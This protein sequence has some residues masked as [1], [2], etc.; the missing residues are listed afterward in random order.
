MSSYQSVT[1][2]LGWVLC[3]ALLALLPAGLAAQE[4]VTI[5]GKVTGSGGEPLRDV[6][7]TIFDVGVGAWTGADGIYHLNVPGGRAQGQ[8]VKMTARLIGFRAGA[9]TVTLTAGSTLEQNFQ[10]ASDPLRLEEVVVTGAGT[11]TQRERLATA[12][13]KVDSTLFQRSNEQNVVQALAGKVP[14]VLTNQGSG[15]AGASTAIVIRGPKSFGTSQPVILLD[16]V[17]LNNQTRGQ[18]ILSGAPATNRAA[19]ISPDD[20]EGGD[21]LS[22]AASTSIYGASAGSAGAIELRSKHGHAGPTT[23]NL[24]STITF[25]DP[26]RTVPVQTKY[27]VGSLGVS[28]ACATTN[29]FIGSNFFSW[30]PAIPDSVP[31]FNHGAEIFETGHTIDNALSISGGNERTTFYLSMSELNQDGFIVSNQDKYERY[32]ARFAGSH[33]LFENLTVNA[34]VQV[35]QTKNT[36]TDRGNSINGVGISALRQPPDFNATQFLGGPNNLHRSWRFPN[37]GPT[38]FT[39]NRGFDNPFYALYND[40]LQGQTGRYLGN[41]N[42][43]WK[44]LLWLSVNW[45]LGG[46]YNADDRTY[47]YGQASSG[48]SGGSIERWQFYDRLFDHT[49]TA[50]ATHQFS[51]RFNGTFTVGQNLNET[52]FRQIDVFGQTWLAP[53]PYKLSNTTTRTLPNDA[54][55]RRRIEGY[56]AQ[57]NADLYDQLFLQA[58][59]RNDAN[60]AFGLGHQHAWYPGASVAWAFSKAVHLP[61]RYIS[62]GKLRT[63]YGQSGNPPPLYA[64]QSVYTTASFADF[65]P[66]SLQGTTIN[67]VGGLYVSNTVGNPNISPER[68]SELEAGLDLS[69]FQG[70]A[71]LS[72]TRYDSKSKDVIFGVA[73]APSTGSTNINLNAGQISNKGWELT[74]GVRVLQRG[75]LSIELSGNWAENRNVVTS[76][77]ATQ[78]QLDGLVP[79]PTVANCGPE[80]KVARCQIGIGSSF[81]GQTTHAQVGYPIGVWRSTDFARC[82]RGL[83]TVSFAGT[84]YDVGTACAGAPDG[85][86]Y[87]APNGFPITD[88]TVR[89][90]GNPWPDWT[91]GLAATVNYKGFQLTAFLD[92]RQGGDVLNMTRSSMDQYGTHFDTQRRGDSVTFGSDFPCYNQT[93]GVLNGPVVGPGAGTKV[94]LGEGWFSNAALAGSGQGATG[95]PITT[96]LEDGTFTRLREV[97]LSYSF[98]GRW[99]SRMAG[100]RQL[101]VKVS[102][103]N[104]GLWSH[105]SGYDP[106]VNL[107]GAQNANRGIDWFNAPLAHS[108]IMQLTLYH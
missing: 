82:G 62:Y 9:A 71:D 77:G 22:G 75:N 58:R 89:A 78:D 57:A 59:V 4:P 2:P 31:V 83:T 86:L 101:D 91:M 25:D 105:Y 94:V 35:I 48:Q 8:Q 96:R 1:R 13:P 21:I 26:V 17:P 15:D 95:G 5:S 52:Y 97:S 55:Q 19:D 68:V 108:Y 79:M 50:V 11:E 10:L 44:P 14:N 39:N 61:E 76:L 90:I 12:T 33:S 27:G 7:V 45:T 16:G 6:N 46:D 23:Y 98:R 85:A 65:N 32:T 43:N 56:F 18:A 51:P 54:E 37:P 80:A 30:G 38:A 92:H 40:L 87:I 67:G 104:L 102:G 107:G 100:L 42:V 29:C 93:C 20:I 63:A 84:S 53:T 47:A 70:K 36:G 41:I 24:R 28:S 103:R 49:L 106:E 73:L 64:T 66:G 72:I 34:S 88:P 3:A 99:V 60:S 81:A 74:S 69:L